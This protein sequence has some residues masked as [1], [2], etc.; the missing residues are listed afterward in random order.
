MRRS[1]EGQA[2]RP[3]SPEPQGAGPSSPGP[4]SPGPSSPSPKK[5]DTWPPEEPHS[6]AVE[7]L[8]DAQ[9]AFM[10][11][12]GVQY[13]IAGKQASA[14]YLAMTAGGPALPLRNPAKPLRPHDGALAGEWVAATLVATSRK[15]N[16]QDGVVVDCILTLKVAT[17]TSIYQN[18][19]AFVACLRA[20]AAIGQAGPPASPPAA[21]D[22]LEVLRA[23]YS[24][25][26]TDALRRYMLDTD[27]V[28]EGALLYDDALS[29]IEQAYTEAAGEQ[30]CEEAML[31]HSGVR[32]HHAIVR[33]GELCPEMAAAAVRYSYEQVAGVKSYLRSYCATECVAGVDDQSTALQMRRKLLRKLHTDKS[34][35]EVHGALA[36]IF[37]DVEDWSLAGRGLYK[38]LVEQLQGADPTALVA[39]VADCRLE[40]GV[41]VSSKPV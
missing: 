8:V 28:L 13:C 3:S 35:E 9:S 21:P 23:Q 18:V 27:G 11:R 41:S 7:V 2:P 12:D 15:P 25:A 37:A 33:W 30:L 22:P 32:E 40:L 6:I 34:G 26:A 16:V 39:S 19:P 20:K 14:I 36:D 29:R 4:S 31:R 17:C 38:S 5:R 10:R 1:P 24:R